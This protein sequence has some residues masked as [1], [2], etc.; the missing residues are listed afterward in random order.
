MKIYF[1]ARTDGALGAGLTRRWTGRKGAPG[2][3]SEIVSVPKHHSG[4]RILEGATEK[5]IVNGSNGIAKGR[6]NWR[7]SASRKLKGNENVRRNGKN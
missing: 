1:A 7:K 2:V 5:E 6:K 3:A 4:L